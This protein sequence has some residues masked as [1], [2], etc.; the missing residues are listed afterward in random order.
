MTYPDFDK[1]FCLYTDSSQE[2]LG[3]VM[4]QER[5]GTQQVIGYGSQTLMPAE[6]TTICI[7]GSF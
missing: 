5:K 1:P 7:Q 4:T 2:G 6:K 3:A